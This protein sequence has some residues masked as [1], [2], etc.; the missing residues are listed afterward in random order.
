MGLLEV[1]QDISL[2]F[3][4]LRGPLEELANVGFM[5]L[6]LQVLRTVTGLVGVALI[7]LFCH[8]GPMEVH[9][10]R[11]LSSY[12]WYAAYYSVITVWGAHLFFNVTA[13]ASNIEAVCSWEPVLIAFNRWRTVHIYHCTQVAFYLNYLFAMLVGMDVR[14]KDQ[15]AFT[16]HHIITL[17]LIIF[18]RNWGYLRVQLAILV[19]H[20][21]ADPWLFF[22]KIVKLARPL[23]TLVPDLIMVWFALVFFYTRWFL[24]LVYPVA[25][26]RD[27]WLRDYGWDWTRDGPAS[28]FEADSKAFV[29]NGLRV[30]YYG[31]A[32]MLLYALYAL[33]VFWGG[34]IIKMAW[35]KL[36]QGDGKG[37][38]N[39]DDEGD[40]P[41]CMTQK[42]K[43]KR[44]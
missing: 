40:S 37:D 20:D 3:F 9:E 36:V 1:L 38:E 14:R 35:K 31:L 29:V 28:W 15:T 18:S 6:V 25:S 21:A 43:K 24:Y 12:I 23:W 41:D 7:E 16:A 11:K 22:A 27:G 10:R 13:W 8:T 39:S 26:C 33:H 34:F 17:L 32:M 4:R 5:F 30:S 44:E 19:L 2:P 42:N